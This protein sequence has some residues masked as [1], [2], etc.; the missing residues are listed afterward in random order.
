MHI[1]I[2]LDLRAGRRFKTDQDGVPFPDRVD[3]ALCCLLCFSPAHN[4]P[5]VINLLS[6][7]PPFFA[8]DAK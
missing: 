4:M 1:E 2:W 7:L 3:C 5:F 8:A 6:F